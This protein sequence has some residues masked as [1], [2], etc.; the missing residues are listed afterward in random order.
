[1]MWKAERSHF[2]HTWEEGGVGR[3]MGRDRE[4]IGSGTRI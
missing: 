1:M 3:E 4:R 2:F